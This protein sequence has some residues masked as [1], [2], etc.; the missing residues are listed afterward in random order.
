MKIMMLGD[1]PAGLSTGTKVWL[2]VCVGLSALLA[3][4]VF[5]TYSGYQDELH[6]HRASAKRRRR[7]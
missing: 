7:A 3:V 5:G 6:R 2:G 4:S 1:A